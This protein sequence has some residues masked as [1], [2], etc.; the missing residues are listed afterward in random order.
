LAVEEKNK[1]MNFSGSKRICAEENHKE[2]IKNCKKGSRREEEGW[3]RRPASASCPSC[4]MQRWWPW[5]ARDAAPVA[6]A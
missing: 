6:M 4:G 5:L 3:G 1:S 2:K